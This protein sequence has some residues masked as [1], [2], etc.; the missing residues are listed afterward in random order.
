MSRDGRHRSILRVLCLGLALSPAAAPVWSAP[1]AT[2]A[3]ETAMA[4]VRD[5]IGVAAA[6]L[7]RVRANIAEARFP[8]AS[9]LRRRQAEILELRT[10]AADAQ[11][12]G[13]RD[14]LSMDA[15]REDVRRLREDA[16]FVQTML[17]EYRRGIGA[18]VAAGDAG[19]L[20]ALLL[21]TGVAAPEA[22]AA[23]YAALADRARALLDAGMRLQRDRIGGHRSTGFTLD[24]AGEPIEGAF[25]TLGPLT[26]FAATRG[27]VAGP[28]GDRP[29][30]LAPI[31]V[32]GLPDADRGAVAA[33]VRTGAGTVPMDVTP[34][35]DA[36]HLDSGEETFIEELRSGG[37]V[38]IPILAVG[39]MALLATVWKFVEL[40][41]C[42]VRADH[43][44]ATVLERLRAGDP[45]GALRETEGVGRPLGDLLRDGIA[46]REAPREHLEEILHEHVVAAVP[47]LERHLG[48]LAVLA[49]IAPLLGLLGTVTGMMHTF[50]LVTLFGTGEAR[51]LSGG[52]S[53]ALITTKYGLGIAIPVLLVHAFLARRVRTMAGALEASA[54]MFATRLK[55]GGG[56][57][58]EASHA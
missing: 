12:R 24:G 19:R 40:R 44:V 6:E 1:M 31:V 45:A 51:V 58:G 4:R 55:P 34:G 48:T 56:Q 33:F 16:Q 54:V 26:Y 57:A 3:V 46:H 9:K 2:G 28:A 8:L 39:F 38:M 14:A 22:D 17:D 29:G 13:S 21:E 49:G 30:R 7:E 36:A 53:E 52:I 10:T 50:Q 11:A 41:A 18:R 5:D 35:M 32:D 15:L 23:A 37:L 20:E 25:V 43:S 47:R 27:D 42:R